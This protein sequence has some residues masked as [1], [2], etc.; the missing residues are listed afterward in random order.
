MLTWGF[1]HPTL[2]KRVINARAETVATN[3]LFRSSFQQRRCLIPAT[4]FL[5]WG[6][7]KTKYLIHADRSLFALAGIYREN[8]FTMLTC[9]PSAWMSRIHDR[10]PVILPKQHYDRW[11]VEGGLDLL[12]PY[13]GTLEAVRLSE[14]PA[15][16]QERK[17]ERQGILFADLEE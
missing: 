3:P 10:M 8:E 15:P 14:P 16:K 11:L 6:A 2:K 1:Q 12:Q 4:G 17:R 13:D 5:E 7:D 9:G